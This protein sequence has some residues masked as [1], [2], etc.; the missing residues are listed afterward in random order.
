MQVRLPLLEEEVRGVDALRA[1]SRNLLQPY[2][3]APATEGELERIFPF[4]CNTQRP[5]QCFQKV[6]T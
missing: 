6:Y 2:Q 1:F 5:R 3:P 4:F